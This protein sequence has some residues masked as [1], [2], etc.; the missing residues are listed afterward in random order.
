MSIYKIA[1]NRPIST[2]MFFIGVIVVGLYSLSR[3][4]IDL[5]PEIDFPAITVITSYPGANSAEIEQNI[6]KRLESQLATIENLK[7]IRSVSS[8][9][10]SVISLEFDWNTNLDES[11]NKIRD[12]IDRISLPEGSTKPIIFK[13]SSSDM[14]ILFYAITAKQSYSG[15][16]KILEEIIVNPLNRIPGVGAVNMLGKPKRILYVELDPI[17]LNAYNLTLEQIAN[18]ISTENQNMPL[19]NLKTGLMDF[20]LRLEGEIETSAELENLIV[21]SFQGKNIY[22]KDIAKVEDRLRDRTNIER[23]LGERGL[24]LLVQKQSGANTVQINQQVKKELNELIKFLPSD[25]KITEI[26]DPSTFIKNSLSNLA[27]T[28]LYAFIFVSLIIITFLGRLRAALIVI[29]T[30][31]ISLLTS[32]LYLYI[33][34][35]TINIISL[36]SLAL[37]IGMVVDDA[38]VVLENIMRHVE[39]GSNPREASIYATNEIW[40]AVIVTTLVIVAVFFPLTLVGGMTGIMFKQLGWI[41]TIT[42][43]SSTIAAIT[44]TPVLTSKF[45]KANNAKS[46]NQRKNLWSRI[47]EKNLISLEQFYEKSLRYI[48]KYKR[49]TL[50]TA[51]V[52]FV[53]TIMLF[54]FIGTD[55]MPQ[56]DQ[57]M[58][59]GNIE[60]AVGTRVEETVK[61][62]KKLEE[63]IKNEM[64]EHIIYFTSCGTFEEEQSYFATFMQSASHIIIFGIRLKNPEERERSSFEIAEML[65]NRLKEIPEITKFSVNTSTGGMS[66]G[67][68]NVTVE[69]YG[70]DFDLTTKLAHQIKERIEKIPGAR[71]ITISRQAEKPVISI[72]LKKDKLAQHGLNTAYVSMLLRNRIT[73]K[74]ASLFREDG[75]EYDIIIRYDENF[76]Q[77]FSDIE[78]MII[79]TPTGKKL[80][81]KEIA[82]LTEQWIPPA[83]ERKRKERVVT[84]SAT[85]FKI[86]LGQLV[87]AIQKE[88]K[89]IELPPGIMINIAGAFEDQQKSFQ[90]LGLLLLLSIILVYLVMA[91][92]FESFRS[93]FIIMFSIPF[94]FSGVA[95]ALFLT[96][97]TMSV[98]AGLGAVLLTGIV[99]KN[100]IVLVD[101]INLMRD[102]GHELYEAIAISGRN[103]LRPILMTALTTIFSMVPLAIFAGEGSELW[104]PLGI[105]VI[106]GLTFSTIVSLYFIPALYAIFAKRGELDKI[107]RIR[108]NYKFIIENSN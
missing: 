24:R 28:L 105:S 10:L 31:P 35:N 62:A 92:Q 66:M 87:N 37:A 21:G 1:V 69:I 76:R 77:N 97:T 59:S 34:G 14:P 100:G 99:V 67:G 89:T 33:S 3:I 32:F 29:L 50:L 85:P 17:K 83:I 12:L 44:L 48:L 79:N 55:F 46:A 63:I 49:V 15:L 108:K 103:R 86:S 22:L 7:N 107:R 53:L 93:P 4:P 2:I 91:A 23:I 27:S 78:N 102:R 9:N 70:H 81:L 38:I 68:N 74:K 72:K 45:L 47:I 73:G 60:L 13:F 98:I 64:P 65:R 82:S 94:S 95:L 6:T 88:L 41:V 26:F 61:T 25:I 11:T 101:Y 39:R 90:D 96:N 18:T 56:S 71:E 8:D 5:Y 19:G 16:D 36:S 52:V 58:I 106:G 80:F 43:C 104:Q 51:L 75:R 42:V 84:I 54:A 20:S 40:L 30:I 57:S